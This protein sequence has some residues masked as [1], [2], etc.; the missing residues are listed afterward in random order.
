MK[1]KKATGSGRKVPPLAKSQHQ[2]THA[3]ARRMRKRFLGLYG[4]KSG[5]GSPL[6][7]GR[8][9]FDK[10]LKD[11]RVEGIRFYAGIDDEGRYTLLFCGI[12]AKGNDV[13]VG[14]IG[15]EPW[16]CPPFCSVTNGVLQF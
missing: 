10:I 15:D 9:I 7:Y 8:N 5:V 11:E 1:P 14:T 3:Q 4:D 13:L 12:D 2:I 6:A 16:R